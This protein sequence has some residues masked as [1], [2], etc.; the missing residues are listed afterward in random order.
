MV[1]VKGKLKL[2]SVSGLVAALGILVLVL[3]LIMAGLGY[4]PREGLFFSTQ[5]HEGA[6]MASV[7]SS[8]SSPAP[9]EA[10]V[11]PHCQ[12]LNSK[13]PDWIT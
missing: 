9:A 4:W 10:Q 2:V 7:S 1:V 11:S 12:D 5:P 13:V 3:G 6:T 8:R